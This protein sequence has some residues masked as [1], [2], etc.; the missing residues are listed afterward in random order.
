MRRPTE[1]DS[2]DLQGL[3]VDLSSVVT[4][5]HLHRCVPAG[6]LEVLDLIP[7]LVKLADPVQ[8]PIDVD[9]LDTTAATGRARRPRW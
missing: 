2:E 4:S 1:P 3:E 5:H 9:I 7:S 6:T 8:P